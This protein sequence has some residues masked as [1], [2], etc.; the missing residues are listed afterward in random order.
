[1]RG[2]ADTPEIQAV[3]IPAGLNR[4]IGMHALVRMADAGAIEQ[5]ELMRR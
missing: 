5:I 2:D 3:R 4:D 1:M